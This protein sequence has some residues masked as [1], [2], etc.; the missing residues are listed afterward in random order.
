[1]VVVGGVAVVAVGVG[2]GKCM[3][4]GIGN[5][6]GNVVSGGWSSEALW[7]VGEGVVVVVVVGVVVG[8]V[9]V[10][11]GVL[12]VLFSLEFLP[13]ATEVFETAALQDMVLLAPAAQAAALM[14]EESSS[15]TASLL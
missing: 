10:V 6:I 4:N 5:G 2:S 12:L 9:V 1:M 8:V 11:V 3:S 14:V 15:T 7:V 13:F